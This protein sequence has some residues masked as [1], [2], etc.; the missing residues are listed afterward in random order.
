MKRQRTMT[1]IGGPKVREYAA[2]RE[3]DWAAYALDR[4]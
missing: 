1:R 4:G 3:S 2:L